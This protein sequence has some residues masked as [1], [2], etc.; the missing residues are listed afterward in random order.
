ML[1]KNASR[2]VGCVKNLGLSL[3]RSQRQLYVVVGGFPR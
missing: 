2:G 3:L 1:T